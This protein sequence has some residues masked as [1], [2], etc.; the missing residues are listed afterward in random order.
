MN[1]FLTYF[2]TDWQAMTA[3]DWLG[4]VLNIGIFIG[5]IVVFIWAF[6]P[7]NKQRLESYRHLPFDEQTISKD[8]HDD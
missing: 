1:K 4:L 8:K 3:T 7:S 5:L 6:R 2:E